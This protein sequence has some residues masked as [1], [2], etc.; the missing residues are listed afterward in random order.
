M[1]RAKIPRL[2]GKRILSILFFTHVAPLLL[3]SIALCAATGCAKKEAFLTRLLFCE[4]GSFFT[5]WPF[6]C[7][8]EQESYFPFLSIFA[9]LFPLYVIE[10]YFYFREINLS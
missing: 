4:M 1:S 3:T 10:V 7:T 9:L 2:K 8:L 6:V 5:Y